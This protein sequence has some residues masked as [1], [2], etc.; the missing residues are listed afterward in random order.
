[1]V[2]LLKPKKKAL[3]PV[4]GLRRP[5]PT[6]FNGYIAISHEFIKKVL[7]YYSKV[8]R[9]NYIKVCMGTSWRALW[10]NTSSLAI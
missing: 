1:M 9:S 5:R 4:L 6:A 2:C 10:T 3:Q 8:W 7:F